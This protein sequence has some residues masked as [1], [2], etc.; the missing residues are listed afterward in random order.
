MKL[1]QVTGPVMA[2]GLEDTVFYVYNR[3]VSLNEVGGEPERFGIAWRNSISATWSAP[4]DWP[5]SLLATSTHDTK[6]SEDVRARLAVLSEMPGEWRRAL[7]R[8]RKLNAGP[9][10][11]GRRRA[12]PDR[13]RRVPPLPD[14]ARRLADGR[15][16][17]GEFP[18]FRARIR[19]Y[20]QK[21]IREA[22]VHTSW[23][24]PDAEYEEAITRF[25]DRVL[26]PGRAGVPRPGPAVQ[27]RIERPGQVNSLAQVALKLA[28]PACRTSTR[29]A[30]CGTCRWS[31]PTTA[32]RSTSGPDELLAEL[33]RQHA[34]APVSLAREAW[35]HPPTGA[36]S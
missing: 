8:W 9:Q 6:R 25:V 21:A 3:L 24:N 26:D 16:G 2:K 35:A 11:R 19:E 33:L 27:G 5:G 14:A 7:E 23:T 29:A 17:A 20:M 13:Q 10:D 18:A 28:A 32:G 34:E 1:Q 15:D 30:S 22:K 36:S 12:R 31:T 4:R